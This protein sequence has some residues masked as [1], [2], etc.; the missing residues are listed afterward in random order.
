MYELSERM[1]RPVGRVLGRIVKR[2]LRGRSG[3]LQISRL[4]PGGFL[5]VVGW[6]ATTDAEAGQGPR[7]RL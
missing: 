7:N 5:E 6:T 3:T 1:T 2:R 4:W